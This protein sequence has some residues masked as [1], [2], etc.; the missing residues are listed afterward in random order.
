VSTV[1]SLRII[2]PLAL[3]ALVAW[4]ASVALAATTPFN[5]TYAGRV[6]EKVSG[7]AVTASA[8]GKG[9]GT[10]VKASSITGVVHA[11]TANP[12]CSPFNGPGSIKSAAGIIKLKVLPVSR[13][14]A[15]G[16]DDQDNISLSGSAKVLGGTKK[17]K[18]AKGTLRFTGHYD[19]AEGKFTVRLRGKLTY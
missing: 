18:R 12:P 10:L 7:T 15:A 13:G 16:S 17:F 14:C 1:K 9:K 8:T 4:V 3:F 2:V 11:S 6:T 5:A 19:R